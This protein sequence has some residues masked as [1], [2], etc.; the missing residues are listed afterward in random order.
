[1]LNGE[2]RFCHLGIANGILNETIF[3]KGRVENGQSDGQQSR[4]SEWGEF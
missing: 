1:M 2:L 3:A 4:Y